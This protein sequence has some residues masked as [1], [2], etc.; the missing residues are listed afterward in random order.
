MVKEVD[1]L[2]G[3]M[4]RRLSSPISA[5][6]GGGRPAAGMG[7]R[8]RRSLGSG[9]RSGDGGGVGGEKGRIFFLSNLGLSDHKD[10][11]IRAW[12]KKIFQPLA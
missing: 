10:G 12:D 1:L 7:R 3:G 8:R 11:Q 6:A 5:V 2:A 9:E 4:G